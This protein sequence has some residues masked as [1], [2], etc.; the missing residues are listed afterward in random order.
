MSV[1]KQ[2]VLGCRAKIFSS[3]KDSSGVYLSSCWPR[4]RMLAGSGCR[5][6]T[7]LLSADGESTYWGNNSPNGTMWAQI[8][9]Q[10]GSHDTAVLPQS[11]ANHEIKMCLNDTQQ[12]HTFVHQLESLQEFYNRNH[13]YRVQLPP[14]WL[15]GY[16]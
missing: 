6:W 5:R 13:L 9:R 10:L 2:I 15:C 1:W 7:S 14:G 16:R 12:C 8:Q 4:G 11:F 3:V